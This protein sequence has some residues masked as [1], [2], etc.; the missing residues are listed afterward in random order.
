[1][2]KPKTKLG[3]WLDKRGISNTWLQ[4]NSGLG[5]STITD[6]TFRG[7]H[8]PTQRTMSKVLKALRKIDPNVKSN[9]FWD[10]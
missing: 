8:S 1:M 4:K 3:K 7:K 5:K 10:M 9:D 6:L 2:F